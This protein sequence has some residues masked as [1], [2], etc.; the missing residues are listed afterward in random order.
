MLQFFDQS[1]LAQLESSWPKSSSNNYVDSPCNS[2]PSGIYPALSKKFHSDLLEAGLLYDLPFTVCFL[3]ALKTKPFVILTGLSGSGKTKLAQ[4]LGRWFSEESTSLDPV[5][6]DNSDRTVD[7]NNSNL[8]YGVV[9]VG[10]DWTNSEC[11]LGYP[12]AL[13]SSR[14]VSTTTLRL[15]LSALSGSTIPH[16]VIFDEMNLSHV[17][18]YFSDFLSAMESQEPLPLYVSGKTAKMVARAFHQQLSDC[19]QISLLLGP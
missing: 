15:L 7:D 5:R 9:A 10:A 1:V 11:V 19:R 3:A 16:I 12:D 4:A 6:I 18:R 13:D 2:P 17:E 8:Q 14:Y